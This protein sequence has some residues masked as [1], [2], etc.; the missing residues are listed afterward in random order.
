[1]D[2]VPNRTTLKQRWFIQDAVRSP[3][4]TIKLTVYRLAGLKD[5]QADTKPAQLAAS[6][7]KQYGFKPSY[8]A[9]HQVRLHIRQN[10]I[11]THNDAFRKVPSDIDRLREGDSNG[12]YR[13]RSSGPFIAQAFLAPF[14][15]RSAFASLPTSFSL[16]G[17]HSRAIKD[18]TL[19]M[20]TAHDAKGHIVVLAWGHCDS[21]SIETWTWFLEQLLVA[22]PHINRE[23][24]CLISDPDKGIAYAAE[25]VLPLVYYCHC[26]QII[27]ENIKARFGREIASLFSS[28]V[29]A[30]TETRFK[31]QLAA[32]K[33]LNERAAEYIDSIEHAR[34]ARY[35]VKTPRFGYTTSN[36][37]EQTN[38]WLR[39]HRASTIIHL[40]DAIWSWQAAQYQIELYRLNR[41]LQGSYQRPRPPWTSKSS[42][43]CGNLQ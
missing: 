29:N 23:D 9:V 2:A 5:V 11:S 38:A 19:L 12:V 39:S 41:L 8:Q 16:D 31:I 34:W 17:C 7:A 36:V 20:A 10:D 37:A 1:M 13:F 24:R 6:M 35:A 43:L 28:L 26:I 30:T 25:T 40:H 42:S 33:E 4:Y 14:P 3:Q 15:A 18:Y 22:Y 21:E 32:I 27:K